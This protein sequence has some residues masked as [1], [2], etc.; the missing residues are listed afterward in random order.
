MRYF[1]FFGFRWTDSWIYSDA[2]FW[3]ISV[4][5]NKFVDLFG[6]VISSSLF[7][8]RQIGGSIRMGNFGLFGLFGFC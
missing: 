6:C 5:L 4:V 3:V 8:V 2:L 7:F 1:G